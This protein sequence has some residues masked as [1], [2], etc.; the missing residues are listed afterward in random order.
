M[1]QLIYNKT[2]ASID[3]L[4]TNASKY[5]NEIKSMLS[6]SK[7]SIEKLIS[8]IEKRNESF[9]KYMELLGEFNYSDKLTSPTDL[10][11][12]IRTASQMANPE[13]LRRKSEEMKNYAYEVESLSKSITALSNSTV[14]DIKKVFNELSEY[15]LQ[16]NQIYDMYIELVSDMD[17]IYDI[18]KLSN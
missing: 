12:G 7:E 10:F 17:S 6:N 18:G 1:E 4:D 9:K 2:L 14:T 5:E 13:E 3:E 8:N 15:I 11:P 16:Q